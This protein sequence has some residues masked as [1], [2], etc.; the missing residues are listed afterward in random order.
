MTL[1][2]T[3]TKTWPMIPAGCRLGMILHHEHQ[4]SWTDTLSLLL[5][6]HPSPQHPS[7][8]HPSPQHPSPLDPSP[9][10]PSPQHPSPL[11]PSPLDP[12]LLVPKS[13]SPPLKLNCLSYSPSQR[14]DPQ[15]PANG[16]AGGRVGPPGAPE[17]AADWLIPGVSPL[18]S[19]K[20]Q[21]YRHRAS[22]HSGTDTVRLHT[23]GHRVVRPA[24]AGGGGGV[25][26]LRPPGRG[27]ERA[28]RRPHVTA[29]LCL[30]TE[31][32]EGVEEEEEVEVLTFSEEIH[33]SEPSLL[34]QKRR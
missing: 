14:R 21:R 15:S 24:P 29:S 31:V 4:H 22:P 8:Q 12:H 27:G 32:E 30:S 11:D 18:E 16:R 1:I 34:G 7:P 9:Q 23:A 20:P 13:H 10:H 6:Q 19:V 17:A 25:V 3:L 33:G 5:P 2:I 28:G 26:G